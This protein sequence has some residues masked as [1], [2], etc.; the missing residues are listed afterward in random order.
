MA[1]DVCEG[2]ARNGVLNEMVGLATHVQKAS[3]CGLGQSAPVA[4]LST[5][6]HFRTEYESHIANEDCKVCRG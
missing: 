2:R 6:E 1:T 5:L 4:F 3:L